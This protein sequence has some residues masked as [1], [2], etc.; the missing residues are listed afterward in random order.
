MDSLDI[1][2]PTKKTLPEKWADDLREQHYPITRVGNYQNSDQQIY[3]GQQVIRFNLPTQDIL[4]FERAH[5]DLGIS[6]T[7]TGGTVIAQPTI[8]STIFQDMKI[9]IGGELADEMLWYSGLAGLKCYEYDK[10]TE[11]TSLPLFENFATLGAR[12]TAAAAGATQ[13]FI[14]DFKAGFLKQLTVFMAPF[15]AQL[16]IEITTAL[17]SNYVI[18]DG[19]AQN[20]T[21]TNPRLWYDTLYVPTE[22]YDHYQRRANNND[23]VYRWRSWDAFVY[24]PVA[25]QQ[26]QINIPLKRSLVSGYQSFFL[27]NTYSGLVSNDDRMT[28]YYSGAFFSQHQF[29]LNN[30]QFPNSA[31]DSP[32]EQAVQY[33]NMVLR[34]QKLF[35]TNRSLTNYLTTSFIIA[36]PFIDKDDTS[37][38]SQG[39]NLTNMGV[40]NSIYEILFT[41]VPAAPLTLYFYLNYERA[42]QIRS[43]RRCRIAV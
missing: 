42:L 40:S 34:E 20:Y 17:P 12:Q 22:V 7:Q 5:I 27:N 39:L 9:K 41:G 23:L 37:A 24:T 36:Q 25:T 10:S 26:A 16:Q 8:A 30:T 21:I 43:G 15:L 29:R 6:V 11:T 18:G 28:T 38:T 3:T 4:S 32:R 19:T 35:S 1:L 13:R 33:L 31:I 2:A 14:L